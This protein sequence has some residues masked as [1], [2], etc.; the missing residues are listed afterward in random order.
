MGSQPCRPHR[1]IT[2]DASQLVHVIVIV[3]CLKRTDLEATVLKR[4]NSAIAE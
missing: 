4:L 1:W 2:C 3:S